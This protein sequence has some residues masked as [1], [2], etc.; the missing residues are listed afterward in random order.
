VS[1]PRVVRPAVLRAVPLDRHAVLE[2]SAGTG[3]TFTLE[4]LVVELILSADAPIDR[5]LV[6]TFT[7]KATNE[8]RLRVRTKLEELSRGE[9]PAPDDAQLRAGDF[10][11]LDDAAQA[12][13][14]RALHAFDGAT[15]ATIHAFCQRVLRENAFGSG[16]LFEEEQVDGRDS[17]ARALREALRREVARDPARAPWLEAALHMGWSITRLEDLLWRCVQAH[18]ELRPGFDPAALDAALQGFPLDDARR[19]DGPDAMRKWGMN[20]ATAKKVGATLWELALLVE[21]AREAGDTP[22]FVMQSEDIAFPHLLEKLAPHLSQ[23]G[24]TGRA[25]AGAFALARATPSLTAALAQT[26]LGPVRHE[27]ARHKRE[28]GQY[29]FDDM[30][31]LVDE[32]LR[33]PRAGALT[34][35][36]RERWRYALIDEFQDTDETQWSIFRRAF[37]ADPQRG[38]STVYL[39][40]DPKQSIYRFRGADVETY[41]RAR[42]DVVQSGGAQVAL[43]TNY[44]ATHPLVAAQ[45]LLFDA[46]APAPFFRGSIGYQPVASGGPD[47]RLLDGGGREVAPLHVF[48]FDRE[49]S[50]VALAARV[51]REIRVITDPARPWQLG[52]GKIALEQVFVLTRTGQEGRTVGAALRAAGVP[53]AFFKEEGLFQTDEAREIRT[54]LLAIDDPGR[55]ACRL[56]AWLT[57]FFAL[58]LEEVERVRDL[59]AT[60]PFHTRLRAWH[61]LAEGREFERLFERIVTDSGILRREIFFA[62]GERELTNYLHVFELLVEQARRTHATLRDLV[63]LLS[64]LIDKTRLTLDLEGNVQRLE[65]ERR[66]VQIMTIHKAKGLEASVVFVVGGLSSAGD[67]EARVYH[68]GGR[69]LAWVGPPSGDVKL[70]I[71]AEER[72]EDQRLMYVALTRAKGRVYLPCVI[73]DGAPARVRGAYDAVNRR[74]VDLL[75]T[76]ADALSVED[77]SPV[78]MAP[79]PATGHAP[80]GEWQP[81]AALLHD[82]DPAPEYARLRERHAG[83]LVTSYT[84]MRGGRSGARSA[85]S[86]EPE[87]R[88]ARKADEAIDQIAVTTLRSARASGVFVHEVLERVPLDSFAAGFE[89]W[90]ALPEVSALF[91]EAIAVHRVDPA[92]RPHAERLVWAAFATPV[93]LPGGAS[94]AGLARASR[95][96]REMEFV[97]P[98]ADARVFVRGSLDL[99]F[100]HGGRTYFVDWKTDALVSYGSAALGAHVEAHYA[101]QVHL[102]AL[103]VVK[104][105]GARTR[106]DYEARFG[107]LLYCF[108]RGMETRETETRGTETR[109]TETRETETRGTETRETETRGL[110]SAR[111]TWDDVLAWDAGLGAKR[112][113]GRGA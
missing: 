97:F 7:E 27:L 56:A 50:L 91:D 74:L 6:V 32:A 78:T 28:V 55:R 60:H 17:F 113:I 64:G 110:W 42:Q 26:V 96:V 106:E 100:E 88:R 57:P 2:A 79:A 84:R 66:A 108:L 92:Q 14:R 18:G 67:R 20:A 13:L 46:S 54:L 47:R 5:I 95:V 45:N 34:S 101:E 15:I 44:R 82:A 1:A 102:Y 40:G 35:A 25:C 41:L 8:L 4:H 99:A 30:L 33:G 77:V 49:I 109:L 69:R 43:D 10:W 86:D 98:V 52:A 62:E 87:V 75:A 83:A 89:A 90:R 31:A 71:A 48:R 37:F 9:G 39:V 36:M 81:P 12:K 104:L 111:P 11:T 24:P 22:S 93:T 23:P 61:L 21:N 72:E 38:K 70:R 73:K 85:W 63:H 19:L 58:P 29:D 53:H 65:S 76:R 103:A 112:F 105:L 51:A 59:P 3:K 107:G 80:E 68:E 16:R 94:L